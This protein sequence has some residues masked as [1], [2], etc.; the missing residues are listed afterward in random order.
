MLLAQRQRDLSR[1]YTELR[2]RATLLHAGNVVPTFT[3]STL[4]GDRVTIGATAVADARQVLFILHTT[5]PYCRATLPIWERLADSLRRVVTPSIELYAISLD[6]ADSTL[7]YAN[8]HRLSFPVL[9]FPEPKLER[10]YRVGAVPQTVVLDHAGHVLYSRTGLLDSAAVL[11]SI[12]QAATAPHPH[13]PA[14]PL[15]P[16]APAARERSR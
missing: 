5:C 2:L 10:L 8:L 3:T 9:L 13:G 4:D 14:V 16:A 12:F 7:A 11:D 6:P 1:A 15:L